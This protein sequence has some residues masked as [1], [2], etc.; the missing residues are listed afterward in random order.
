MEFLLNRF[1]NLTV[2]LLVIFAQ[3]IL[4]A[5][6]VKTNQDVTL[7]RVWSVTAITPL[8]RVL[9]AFRSST[10]GFV[11][12]YFVLVDV[13]D[14]NKKLK[15]TVDRLKL[16]NQALAEQLSTADRVR[17]LQIFQERSPS[18]TIAARIIANGTGANSK[19]VFIDRGSTAGI[20]RGM[21]V[22]TPDGIVGKVLASYPT[23]STVLLVTDPSFAAG[24][25][26]QKNRV[27]GT[28]KGQGH[29]TA[30][31]DYIQ[32]EEKLD[33]G[34]WFYTSG[35]DRIFPKGLPVGQVTVARPGRGRKEVFVNPSGMQNGLEEAATLGLGTL[36]A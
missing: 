12:D 9:E 26:S 30:T 27:R 13:R 14:E 18:K 32:N 19:V 7:L 20:E 28:I 23:A 29:G 22:I 36:L 8:A 3:L 6:Q 34:E 1:R 33:P 2:L 5:Y 17:A 10:V 15:G 24:V 21:P 4:L 31:V 35:D 16:K 25:I 11:R